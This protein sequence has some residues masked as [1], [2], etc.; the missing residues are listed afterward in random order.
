MQYFLSDY[1]QGDLIESFNSVIL[2]DTGH[3][4]YV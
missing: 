1:T 3:V 4:P 2:L